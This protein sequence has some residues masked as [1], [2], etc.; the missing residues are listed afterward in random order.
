MYKFSE[1]KKVCKSKKSYDKKGA[2]TVRNFLR[3]KEH[4]ELKIYPC[5]VGRHW[6]LTSKG[7]GL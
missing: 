2:Q 3:E 1:H 5:P 4:K 7:R 6:H